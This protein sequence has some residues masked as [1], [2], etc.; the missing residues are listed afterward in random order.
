M[1][2]GVYVIVDGRMNLRPQLIRSY[3]V[4]IFGVHHGFTPLGEV[5]PTGQR[6]TVRKQF[7]H[8]GY[9]IQVRS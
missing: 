5:S 8:L 3:R 4:T 7:Y 9:F 2:E 6:P 1:L